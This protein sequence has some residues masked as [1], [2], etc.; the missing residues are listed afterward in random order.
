MQT[1]VG[2]TMEDGIAY[3]ADWWAIIFNPSFPYRLA[4]MLNAS[5]LT[6]GF[7][8]IAVGA[9][10]LLAGRHSE[11]AR[12]MLRMAVALTAVLAPLQLI[13]GDMHAEN[14]LKYQPT[15]IA[16]MEGHW[17][18]SK[19]A[20]FEIL[21]WPDESTESNLYAI[22][23]P[24][25]GSLLVT[26][27]WDGL[28]P[29]LN[30]VPPQDRP[31]VPNVFFGF[32]IMIGIGL[33]MIAAAWLGGWLLWRGR[34]FE[35]RWYLQVVAQT[36]W[37]GFVAVISGWVVSESGRQPW[38][39][40]GILRT[41]DAVSP[42]PADSVAATLI[43]FVLVYGVVFS[44]GIYFINRLIAQGIQETRLPERTPHLA[45]GHPTFDT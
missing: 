11:E 23:L 1:P 22:S 24:H 27:Q 15:K 5:L 45:A 26:R 33:Y 30:D 36:W 31:P 32:R 3:P 25:I 2:Y 7:V 29:G 6:G 28:F 44:F 21:A 37:V 20:P 13:I 14:T 42:V 18:G 10:Y 4:H 43:L 34:L 38:I 12:T 9:R 40:D 35:T 16:A 17:D 39:V 41:A 8:G 19:P